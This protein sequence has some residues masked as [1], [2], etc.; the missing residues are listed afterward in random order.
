MAYS[1]SL[2]SQAAVMAQAAVIT[3][4]LELALAQA[5]IPDAVEQAAAFGR[6][7]LDVE[8]QQLVLSIGAARLLDAAIGWHE[9]MDSGLTHVVADDKPM[10]MAALNSEASRLVECEFRIKIGRASCRERV[11]SPV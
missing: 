4:E 10:L 6:W 8:S 5:A 9:D 1:S 11:S 3:P 7:W 2:L